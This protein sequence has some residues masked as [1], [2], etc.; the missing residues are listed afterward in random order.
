MTKFDSR[1]YWWMA[2]L[3][4]GLPLSTCEALQGDCTLSRV[5]AMAS[6]LLRLTSALT[7]R[8]WEPICEMT[9]NSMMT[10]SWSRRAPWVAQISPQACTRSSWILAR[11]LARLSLLAPEPDANDTCIAAFRLACKEGSH[12]RSRDLYIFMTLWVPSFRL[13]FLHGQSHC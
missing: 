3:H 6:S 5:W 13:A 11:H 7:E 1:S 10:A 2:I 8:A 4:V 9:V 12:D